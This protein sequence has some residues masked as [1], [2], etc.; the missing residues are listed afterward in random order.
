[1]GK[2]VNASHGQLFEELVG[3]E[4]Q[5]DQYQSELR[6]EK[7]RARADETRGDDLQDALAKSQQDASAT[8]K[9]DAAG[10]ADLKGELK[11]EQQEAEEAQVA[12]KKRLTDAEQKSADLQK[13]LEST[14]ASRKQLSDEL[15]DS[16]KQAGQYQSALSHENKRARV[17]EK[18][19]DELQDALA[20]SQQDAS[21]IVYRDAARQAD[22]KGELK[23][24]QQEAEEEEVASKKRLTDAAQKSA[25]LQKSLE[26]TDASRKQLS[27]ELVYSQK[28]AGQYQSALSHENKRARVDEKKED[29]L[30]DALAKSQQDASGIVY[31]DA[32]R[33]A[34]LKGELKSKQQEAEEE[35]V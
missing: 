9:R 18:K 20:K 28:Q 35:E 34:D 5:E 29:E 2:S 1:M 17:D 19:E 14:D 22:L 7:T 8:A 13:S 15:V 12:S 24:K 27:D 11:S 3:A 23:S 32:A 21:G 33:Q 31:R 16:Q 30:Q 10:E 6:Q 26:S 25:D 4:K